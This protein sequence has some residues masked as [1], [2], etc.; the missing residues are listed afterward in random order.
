MQRHTLE[1]RNGAHPSTEEFWNL[2][3]ELHFKW[4]NENIKPKKEILNSDKELIQNVNKE[5][6]KKCTIF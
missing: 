4:I 2:N 6:H 3:P 5:S 1:N